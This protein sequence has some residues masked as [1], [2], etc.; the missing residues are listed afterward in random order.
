[1]NVVQKRARGSGLSEADIFRRFDREAHE[2]FRRLAGARARVGRTPISRLSWLLNFA[3]DMPEK[4]SALDQS[5]LADLAAAIWTFAE[6]GRVGTMTRDASKPVSASEVADLAQTVSEGI[7]RLCGPEPD[8]A[9]WQFEPAKFG[10]LHRAV[11]ARTFQNYYFG[12]F[13]PVFLMAVADLL[14]EEGR[15]IKTCAWGQCSRF[16]VRRKRG[17]YCSGACSQKARTKRY[18]DAQ[19]PEWRKKRHA[20]YVREVQ[21]LKG[22]AVAAMVK[23]RPI[24]KEGSEQK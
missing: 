15:R 11:Q 20:Y 2:W 1:M 17:A 21:K 13:R 7:K 23:M 19:G 6:L 14:R 5:A 8:V 9:G 3:A 24:R 18:R 16:F 4:L 12:D 10:R 22:R